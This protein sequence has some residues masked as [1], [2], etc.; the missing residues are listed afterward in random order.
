MRARPA[1]CGTHT[2]DASTHAQRPVTAGIHP[3]TRLAG[4]GTA[5]PWSP[6]A[7]TGSTRQ[8]CP[9][10]STTAMPTARSASGTRAIRTPPETGVLSCVTTRTTS[11]PGAPKY[12]KGARTNTRKRRIHTPGGRST[13]EQEGTGVSISF[14]LKRSQTLV[15]HGAFRSRTTKRW[16]SRRPFGTAPWL[17]P[18]SCEHVQGDT[19]TV[20]ATQGVEQRHQPT[21]VKERNPGITIPHLR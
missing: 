18:E 17:A 14:L 7:A 12:I 4:A 8:P 9:A 13:A 5:P 19:N 6:P 3:S 11:L 2:T 16:S 10:A 1:P 20:P 21:L 15:T